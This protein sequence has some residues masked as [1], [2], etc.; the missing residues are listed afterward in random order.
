MG[1]ELTVFPIRS[2]T[3]NA[4]NKGAKER[5]TDSRFPSQLLSA[6]VDETLQMPR[7]LDLEARLEQDPVLRAQVQALRRL[8]A[9]IRANGERYSAPDGLH[10]R[11]RASS[12]FRVAEYARPARFDWRRWL[13]WR[14]LVPSF[15]LVGL[16]LLGRTLPLG[17]PDAANA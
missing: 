7:Q 3:D 2:S 4:V 15:S 6:F 10:A 13:D 8:C 14:P 16:V 17:N 1:S 5:L 11:I 9:A 12:A